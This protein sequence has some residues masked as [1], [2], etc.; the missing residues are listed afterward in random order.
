MRELEQSAGGRHLGEPRAQSRGCCRCGPGAG[1]GPA[2]NGRDCLP[3]SGGRLGWF[4]PDAVLGRQGESA[5]GEPGAVDADDSQFAGV[6]AGVVL[7]PAVVRAG[8]HLGELH[9]GVGC[10]FG[11]GGGPA[12]QDAA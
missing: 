6:A 3:R 11:C 8:E 4:V 5:I 9:P 7:Q 2:P 12:A 10:S 1:V